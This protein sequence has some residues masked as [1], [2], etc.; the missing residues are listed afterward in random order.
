[1]GSKQP[2]VQGQLAAQCEPASPARSSAKLIS[3]MS[4]HAGTVLWLVTTDANAAEVNGL[5]ATTQVKQGEGV[6]APA[7]ARD[8]VLSDSA[9]AASD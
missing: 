3:C 4:G 8:A 9:A 2:E 6:P 7:E 1:M 5:G